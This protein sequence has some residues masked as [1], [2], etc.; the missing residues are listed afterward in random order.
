MVSS[1]DTDPAETIAYRFREGG[2]SRAGSAVDC[3]YHERSYGAL[4][5]DQRARNVH[6]FFGAHRTRLWD[7]TLRRQTQSKQY[8]RS[9]HVGGNTAFEWGR[10]EMIRSVTLCYLRK[11]LISQR[12]TA[13]IALRSEDPM[14]TDSFSV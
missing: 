2:F 7:N 1:Q 8:R 11:H 5:L 6:R 14:I 13:R 12:R 10:L 9:K 3:G 4:S